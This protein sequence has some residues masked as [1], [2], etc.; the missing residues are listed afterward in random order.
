MTAVAN[1]LFAHR[2]GGV[3]VLRVD[4]TDAARSE[5]RFE[6]SV[7]QDAE[8][9]GLRFDEGPGIGGSYG[10]YRQSERGALYAQAG[11]ELLAS[12]GAYRCFCSEAELEVARAA[13]EAEGRSFRYDR[14]CAQIDRRGGRAPGRRGGVVRLRLHAAGRARS[15][16]RMRRAASS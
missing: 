16:S 3:F 12:R 7:S 6:R 15:R 10:P 14:R 8:W 1:Y 13:A 5:R 9:L 11:A 2:A 4:D